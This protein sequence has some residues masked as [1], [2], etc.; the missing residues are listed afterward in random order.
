M[1]SNENE[2]Q[3]SVCV[4]T[5]NQE[6]YIAE[7]LD[8]LISQKTNFKFEIIVGEDCSTDNTRAT[9]QE[10]VDKYPN[11]IVPLFFE[12]NVGPVE[13]IKAVYKRAKGKYIAHLDGDDMALPSKLQKQFDILENNSDCAICV[14]NMNA[15]D[16]YGKNMDAAF[17]DFAEKKYS[18]LDMYLIN[19]FFIHS[20]KM[21]VNRIEDYIDHLHVRTLDTEL[22]IEQAKQGNIYFLQEKLGAYRQFVGITYEKK[23]ISPFIPERIEYVYKNANTNKF[24]LMELAKIKLKYKHTLLKYSFYYI[25]KSEPILSVKFLI[26]SIISR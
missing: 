2:I 25:R 7:C 14:H 9:V 26:K 12:K 8:S 17:K 3:V 16:N 4:V 23:L 18:L 5:Y 1:N 19:P 20:S 11:L 10:Y 13:N 15:I 22:H 24:G 6:N 21:F